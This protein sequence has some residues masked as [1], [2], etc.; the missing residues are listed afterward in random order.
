VRPS[1]YR[2][3]LREFGGGEFGFIVTF[4]ADPHSEWHLPNKQKETSKYLPEGFLAFSDDF[5]GGTYVF[6]A[7]LMEA[8]LRQSSKILW[9]SSL[10]THMNQ[11]SQ[12]D[13]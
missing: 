3:F 13:A 9:N 7:I 5:A 1:S 10:A 8:R 11:P 4:S 12:G 6:N 2:A